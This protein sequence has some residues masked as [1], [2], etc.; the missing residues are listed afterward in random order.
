MKALI[1][2]ASVA[3][4][5][6]TFALWVRRDLLDTGAWTETSGR[7]IADEDVRAAVSDF[8][9]ERIDANVNRE[10]ARRLGKDLRPKTRTALADPGARAVW[11][12]ANRDAHAQIVAI[13][14]GDS[15][16]PAVLDLHPVLE[17]IAKQV[18][19]GP[20]LAAKLPKKVG[21]LTVLRHNQL[22]WA[23]TTARLLHDLA[24]V[25]I[26]LAVALYAA[27]IWLARGRRREAIGL[28]ALGIVLIGGVVLLARWLGGAIFNAFLNDTVH[29]DGATGAIWSIS[30]S[31]LATEAYILLGAGAVALIVTLALGRWW[32]SSETAP[33]YEW[34]DE[35]DPD[36]EW[37]AEP[38]EYAAETET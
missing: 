8:L 13:V 7:L 19:I 28:C 6:A 16:D 22:E 18:G 27:A 9:V 2:L 38:D 10:I 5:I 1:A 12:K 31:A 33:D 34:E 3:L 23:Q 32:S 15:T 26:A 24:Y 14:E 29:A 4:L 36:P 21:R 35:P 30:T 11:V 37:K 20:A 17:E 25:L